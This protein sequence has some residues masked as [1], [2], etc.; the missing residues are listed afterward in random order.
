[1]NEQEPVV[2]V[3]SS[4]TA[5]TPT[6]SPVALA[7]QGVAP[8]VEPDEIPAKIALTTG[9]FNHVAV[10]MGV[11]DQRAVCDAARIDLKR[12]EAVLVETDHGIAL[13]Q[14]LCACAARRD[15]PPCHIVRAA[16][17]DDLRA[18]SHNRVR[19]RE[20]FRFCNERIRAHQL[21]MKLVG[22]DIAH[23]GTRA[24]FHFASADRIDFRVLV[25]DLAARFHTRIEMRQIGVR[26]AARHTGGIG[27]CGRQLCCATWLQ[28]FIPISIRMAKDQ[29][30]ALNNQKLS[31]VCGR[32][33]CCLDYEEQN[34]EEQK[35]LLPKLGKRVIT[36]QGEGRVKD[37]NVLKQRVRVE[38]ADGTYS[39]F[40]VQEVSRPGNVQ[41]QPREKVAAPVQ[42]GEAPVQEGPGEPGKKRRK[43]RRRHKKGRTN[44]GQ[45][46]PP[47]TTPST[48]TPAA[49]P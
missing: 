16:N 31:G 11:P 22:V 23:A 1:M 3:P 33:R 46:P 20:A 15:G 2:P 39:D 9:R 35:R 25:K 28:S 29:N 38:L 7:M 13:G 5:A 45:S 37:V 30:L 42:A 18:A 19:A 49:A 21:P 26:D 10:R 32:L 6:P 40:D 34:Y 43:R 27:S 17:A 12:D 47:A 41:Q 36:P 24:V 48:P 8:I 4:A 14:V 44:S